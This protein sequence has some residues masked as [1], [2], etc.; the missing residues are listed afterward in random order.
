MQY[1]VPQFIEVED[2]IF[3]P[4][5]F[6]QFL[7]VVGGVAMGFIIWTLIPIK[8]IAIIIAG[9]VVVFF[10][11]AAFYQVN[12]RPFLHYVENY[13]KYFFS[14]KIYLWRKIERKQDFPVREELKLPEPIAE[15]RLNKS[16][17]KD[18]TFKLDVHEKLEDNR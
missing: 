12:S 9:P 2:K 3:G 6:K 15:P 8:F 16:K 11:M 1:Q 17:L 5:T 18:L 10:L 13:V 14:K 7:Y 4:F